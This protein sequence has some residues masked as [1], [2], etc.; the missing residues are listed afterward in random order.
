MTR[1]RN[2]LCDYRIRSERISVRRTR[3][4]HVKD[5]AQAAAK[6]R[7]VTPPTAAL[8]ADE[9]VYFLLRRTPP[10]GMELEDSHKLRFPDSEAAALH[11]VPRPKL[12]LMIRA[13][14]FDTVEMCDDDEISRIGL[15]T[16]YGKS[17]TGGTCQASCA[18]NAKRPANPWR[19]CGGRPTGW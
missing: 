19:S 15:A 13:G 1:S 14:R 6:V 9:T 4:P 17:A 5:V 16:L 7:E 10:S 3:R 18:G 11:I 8:L 2:P 12:D